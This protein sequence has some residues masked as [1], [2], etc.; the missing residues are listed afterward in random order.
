MIKPAVKVF[1]RDALVAGW[2]AVRPEG[3]ALAAVDVLVV[4]EKDDGTFAVIWALFDR[5]TE[6]M[7]PVRIDMTAELLEQ[8]EGYRGQ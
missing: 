4:G 8:L 7:L 1:D 5:N 6:Q 3:P 2:N